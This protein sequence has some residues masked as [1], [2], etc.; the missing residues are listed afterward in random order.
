MKVLIVASYNSDKFSP[1]VLEQANAI[2]SSGVDVVFYGFKG[3]GFAGYIRARKGMMEMINREKPDI[4]HAHYGLSG[5]LANM[6]RKVPVITTYHG[7]DIHSRGWLLWFSK[8]CMRLSAYNIFVGQSL[9]DIAKYKG[10]NYIVQ[11]CGLNL[12]EIIP[13][14]RN[15]ARKELGLDQDKIYILFSGSFGNS[16]KNYQLAKESTDLITNCELIELKNYTRKEVCLLMNA[17]NLQLTTSLRESGPLVVKEAMACDT[18]VVT[19]DVGDVRWVIGG[20]EGCYITSYNPEE[21]AGAIRKAIEF[22]GAKGRTNGRE[23]IIEIGLDNS[24][25]AKKL[26]DIYTTILNKK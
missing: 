9:L 18:S 7:S 20:T 6:Q 26:I 16:V 5:L 10:K 4:I 2:L 3:K 8:L 15:D 21:C 1:F 22:S 23:R 12:P 24:L 13:I 19:T 14:D 17:V 11:S 25:I